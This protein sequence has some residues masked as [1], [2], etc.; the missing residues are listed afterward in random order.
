MDSTIK[1]IVLSSL[2]SVSSLI[3][4]WFLRSNS[5]IF[6]FYHC[7]SDTP[8][9]HT[10]GLFTVKPVCEFEKDL[11]LLLKYYTPIDIR[12]IDKTH[13]A[14][15]SKPSFVL[16]FD[17]G[18][19]EC[20][21][22]IAPILLK[23]GIPATFFV[24]TAFIDNKALFYRYKAALLKSVI[25]EKTLLDSNERFNVKDLFSINYKTQYVLDQLANHLG[26]SFNEFL[27]K[28][29][30]YLTTQQIESLICNSFT[31]G[32]H[33]VDHPHFAD[34]TFEEQIAQIND[35]FFV[36]ENKFR[37]KERYFA[38]PFSDNG[39]KLEFF[40][41]L[42]EHNIKYSFG[43]AGIKQDSISS[44]IQRIALDN[45]LSQ[46]INTEIKSEYLYRILRKGLKKNIIK[47]S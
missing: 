7:I 36:L 39:V 20:H 29:Q 26:Y 17:D 24:N 34:L 32:S 8:P 6:P 30:P 11:D 10:Q 45:P 19:K 31:I 37:I 43:T 25:T 2:R 21:D 28:E 13:V 38:F 40:N 9:L 23:K 15:R 3:P 41:F 14:K 35:S 42:A 33:S 47:R 16:T 46:R 4:L 1:K 27:S 44:N 12:D 18:L 5:M 22:I